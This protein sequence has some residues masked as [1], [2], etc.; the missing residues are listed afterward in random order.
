MTLRNK[1]AGSSGSSGSAGSAGSAGNV[2]SATASTMSAS[3]PAVLCTECI[4]HECRRKLGETAND[5]S[6]ATA[7]A[8]SRPFG[9]QDQLE[10]IA[11]CVSGMTVVQGA[12]PHQSNLAAETSRSTSQ[13]A[14]PANLG[15][16]GAETSKVCVINNGIM[17]VRRSG[18]AAFTCG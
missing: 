3:M 2:G 1:E 7:K 13:P 15:L 8:N 10:D 5:S 17:C 6:T 16:P 12:R 14:G 18:R 4:G 11:K 9:G